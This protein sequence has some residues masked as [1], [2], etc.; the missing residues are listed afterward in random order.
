MTAHIKVGVF[1]DGPTYKLCSG[2]WVW[3]HLRAMLHLL[4]FPYR[5]AFISEST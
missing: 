3:C 4:R 2:P 1:W 5:T